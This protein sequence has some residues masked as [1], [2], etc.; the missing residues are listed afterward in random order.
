[1]GIHKVSIDNLYTEAMPKEPQAGGLI[2]LYKPAC[3]SFD[4]W[5]TTCSTG[6][7]SAAVA[8]T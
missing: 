5:D 3:G 8:Q 7:K 2:S 1:M 4:C 6:V